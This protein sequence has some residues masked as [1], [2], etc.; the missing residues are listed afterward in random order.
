MKKLLLFTLIVAAV[1]PMPVEAAWRRALSPLAGVVATGVAGK[2]VRC[3]E[4]GLDGELYGPGGEGYDYCKGEH[5]SNRCHGGMPNYLDRFPGATSRLETGKHSP[6]VAPGKPTSGFE[7]EPLPRARRYRYPTVMVLE[8]S[9]SLREL[10]RAPE[11]MAALEALTITN[12]LH[13][14]LADNSAGFVNL[15]KLTIRC[16][17]YTPEEALALFLLQQK[18]G[19]ECVCFE[20]REAAPLDLE[21]P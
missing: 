5:S 17:S 12:G 9:N 1:A 13:M 3:V 19:L 4:Y 7:D 11:A 6:A 10:L 18:L 2:I 20:F 8:D 16:C 15:K 14:L 21:R